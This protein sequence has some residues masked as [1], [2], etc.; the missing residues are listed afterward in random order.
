MAEILDNQIWCEKLPQLIAI[1][2]NHNEM[3][4]FNQLW[5]EQFAINQYEYDV[6]IWKKITYIDDYVAL[7]NFLQQHSEPSHILKCRLQLVNDQYHWFMLSKLEI[8]DSAGNISGLI[9]QASDINASMEESVNE[10]IKQQKHIFNTSVDCI[11][12]L[13]PDSRLIYM[14]QAGCQALNLPINEQKF[15]MFWTD[16]LPKNMQ[17]RCLNAIEKAN[18]GEFVRFE[19]DILDNQGQQV[20]WDNILTPEYDIHGQVVRILGISRNITEQ[21]L[22][23]DAFKK[24][25]ELDD[26]TG[27]LNRRLFK[28]LL[29]KKINQH[30]NVAKK[31]GLLM[32]DLDHFKNVNDSLGHIAGD[33]LLRVIANRMNTLLSSDI[34]VARLGGDEFAVIVPMIHDPN[35]VIEV[36]ERILKL[37]EQ[38][39]YFAGKVVNCGM[40]IGCA[41]YPDHS[42]VGTELLRCADIALNEVKARGRGSVELLDINALKSVEVAMDQLNVA[43]M[44]I[45]KDM[46]TPYYQPQVNLLTG[47]TIGFEALLRWHDETGMLRFPGELLEAFHNYEWAK[48]TSE[49]MQHKIFNDIYQWM[50]SGLKP[51]PV[52]INIAPIEFLRDDCAEKFIQRL[53]QYRIPA[54]YINIEITEHH[55]VQRGVD[56]VKRA[57]R[58]LRD[59]GIKIALDDFGTG[60]SSLTHLRTFAVDY[61]KIDGQFVRSVQ[62]DPIALAIIEAICQLAPSLSLEVIA[63]GIETIEQRDLVVNSGCIYGQGFLY[64]KAL[65]EASAR[66][67]LVVQDN[68]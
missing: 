23:Q 35:E 11:K 41:I 31:L 46:I 59:Y 3:V 24:A 56:F 53:E 51:V 45:Q 22:I 42:E 32:I 12:I 27:L 1:K 26:L 58:T 2:Y 28:K 47:E 9:I 48:K 55:F 36:G 60:Y 65:P 38:P 15:G 5:C 14:N 57:L 21:R 63:E 64:N 25:S 37:I 61:V 54:E 18:Q 62:S 40:S 6:S 8:V 67:F 44:I 16:L 33:H 20:Y 29:A 34:T 7:D 49:A 50:N 30:K 13:H 39:V 52:S 68:V 43:R 4:Y 17:K 10:Q 19:M 66:K